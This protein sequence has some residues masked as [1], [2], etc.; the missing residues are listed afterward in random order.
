M[1]LNIADVVHG[2]MCLGK[3]FSYDIDL[4]LHRRRSEPN[5]TVTVIVNAYAFDDGMHM[6]MIT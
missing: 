1:S 2:Q 6:V 4:S 3:R 5:F